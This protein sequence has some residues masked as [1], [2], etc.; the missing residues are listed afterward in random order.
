MAVQ[1]IE[2]T[3]EMFKLQIVISV[4]TIFPGIVLLII[5]SAHGPYDPGFLITIIA[6]I[7]FL[8]GFVWLAVVKFLAWWHHG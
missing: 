1:T 6:P 3:S 8:R 7:V 4:L 2:Q 5:A